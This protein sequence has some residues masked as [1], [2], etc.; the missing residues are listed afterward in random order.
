MYGKHIARGSFVYQASFGL[1]SALSLFLMAGFFSAQNPLVPLPKEL[2][3]TQETQSTGERELQLEDSH[4]PTNQGV[5][6]QLG[7]DE[8]ITISL[9][10][11]DDTVEQMSLE[12]YLWGVLAA[13]MPASFPLEALKAQVVAARTYTALRLT[14]PKHGDAEICDD[15]SCCQ[16]Y[17][18][19]AER[20][21]LWGTDAPFYQEYLRLAVEE[22]NG[23]YILYEGEPIDA[24][25]FSSS[26]GQ[27][28]EAQEVWGSAL[29]YLQS[30]PS[31][32]GAEVPN[33]YTEVQYT[34]E[35]VRQL[36]TQSYPQVSLGE[37][38]D[39]WF[40]AWVEDSAGG[41]A[42]MTVGGITLTGS[43]LRWLFSLRSSHFTLGYGE[44]NFLFSVT[45]Y[46]HGVGMS[47]YGAKALA[48]EGMDFQEILTW[49]YTD[50][51]LST[52]G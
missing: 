30:V 46:G 2:S 12:R 9:L 18:D 27:T 44:G 49:Y 36:L 22:S 23:L 7:A 37:S 42:Q 19:V 1:I 16:A 45:G 6:P 48:E 32:E 41:V 47:Q 20:M 24:L 4:P 52:Y 43:Q 8:A 28:L 38:P 33:Y 26:G 40:S 39:T 17:M 3:S 5:F 50:C 10:R 13:E 35:E 15:S 25:F 34:S 11:S 31:P 21:A 14:S 29:P 51:Q